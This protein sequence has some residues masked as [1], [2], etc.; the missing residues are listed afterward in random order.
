MK[1]LSDILES[2]PLNEVPF[3]YSPAQNY[4]PDFI[5]QITNIEAF[6]E[7]GNNDTAELILNGAI[8]NQYNILNVSTN[9]RNRNNRFN[10]KDVLDAKEDSIFNTELKIN[11]KELN[12]YDPNV[13]FNLVNYTV[14]DELG[15]H[16][17]RDIEAHMNKMKANALI[18]ALEKK[19]INMVIPGVVNFFNSNKAKVVFVGEQITLEIPVYASS[20]VDRVTSG[21]YIVLKTKHVF[22]NNKYS[23][24]LTCSR[25]TTKND[26][27]EAISPIGI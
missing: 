12:E 24:G 19:K 7:S 1:S 26:K 20:H 10:I 21:S 16:D 22:A 18:E 27:S 25:L 3:T 11:D 5:R 2:P 17:E 8:Q 4:N 6:E 13:I 15:Y 14:K 23:L 9:Q